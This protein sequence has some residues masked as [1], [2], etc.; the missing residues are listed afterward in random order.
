M[1]AISLFS[2]I[3]VAEFYLKD[4]GIDVILASDIDKRRC[5]VHQCLYPD[6]PMICGDLVDNRVK[7]AIIDAVIDKGVDLII[8]TPPCQGMSTVGKNKGRALSASNDRRNNLILETFEFIDTLKPSY[9]IFENVP[10]LLKVKLMFN[11]KSMLVEDIFKEK[12]GDEY[13]LK[14]NIF[15]TCHYGIPQNRERVFIRLFK[16]GLTWPDPQPDLIVKTLRDSIGSLPSIE[17]GESS[18]LKN[19]WAR[20][21]PDSQVDWM[22]HTPTGCSAINNKAHYPCKADGERIKAYPNCYKRM[23]WDAPSPTVTMRN[24]IMSSQD[25]VHPGRSLGNGLWSD[26]RVLTLRE[27]LIVM[28][29]PPDMDVPTIVSDTAFRQFVGEGI[30]PLMMKKIMEG[31]C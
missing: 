12:Y 22:R 3:G 5:E 6:T 20:K 1:K 2:C 21:H 18:T 26:A 17:A 24:E 11:G 27:L 4:L 29:L 30:P 31:L 19:H 13:N 25:K 28:S 23:T 7:K 14:I 10:Q 15:N 9:V 16:K 8:S